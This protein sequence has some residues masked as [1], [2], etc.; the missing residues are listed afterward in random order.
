MYLND[1][2]GGGVNLNISYVVVKGCE[3]VLSL[4]PLVSYD[5]Q[6]SHQLTHPFPIIIQQC[7]QNS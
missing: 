5:D 3:V 6:L 1:L 4:L 2:G 7:C